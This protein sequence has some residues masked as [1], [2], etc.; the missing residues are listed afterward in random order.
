[1]SWQRK[2]LNLL[3]FLVMALILVSLAESIWRFDLLA[4]TV[5]WEEEVPLNSGEIIWVKRTVEYT[6]QGGGGNPLDVAYRPNMPEKLQFTWRG[7]QYS[8]GGD[9]AIM[10]V[11]IS[12]S[13]NQPV[14]VAPKGINNWIRA[15]D[16]PCVKPFYEQ[17]VVNESKWQLLPK[18]ELWTL[19]LPRNLM[20]HRY[21]VN[22]VSERYSA[23]NRQQ[24]D[25]IMTIQSPHM[26]RIDPDYQPEICAK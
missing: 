14:L 3:V 1:M 17:F 8:Y 6:L 7:K 13:T 12:P 11:A 4:K 21:K 26:A 22:E 16:F 18:L 2:G 25:S 20:A 10:L 19:D 15:R 9:A 23:V 5:Q 24:S